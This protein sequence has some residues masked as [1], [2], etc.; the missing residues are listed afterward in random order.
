MSMHG[1]LSQHHRS[2]NQLKWYRPGVPRL[3]QSIVLFHEDYNSY[4]R[5]S[6]VDVTRRLSTPCYIRL[7]V[8]ARPSPVM[9]G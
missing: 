4:V 1:S 5:M 9:Q 6:R 7:G 2:R 8:L 3:F